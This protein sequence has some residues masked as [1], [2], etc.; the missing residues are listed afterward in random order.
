MN[1][2]NNRVRSLFIEKV[3]YLMLLRDNL[4]GLNLSSYVGILTLHWKLKKKYY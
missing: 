3:E 4:S 2:K 1:N